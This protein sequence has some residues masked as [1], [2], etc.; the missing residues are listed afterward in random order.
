[1]CICCCTVL[2]AQA[3]ALDWAEQIGNSNADLSNALALDATGNVVTTGCYRGQVDFDPGPGIYSMGVASSSASACFVQKLTNS[4]QFIWARSVGTY[5]I[6]SQGIETDAAGAIYVTGYFDGTQD[7]DPG[8]AVY[9]VTAVAGS[10]IFVVKLDAAGNFRWVRTFSGGSSSNDNA[11]CIARGS[12]NTMVISGTVYG[13]VDFDPGPGVAMVSYADSLGENIYVLCLD[14]AGQ[15]S[16]A[17][18]I[19]GAGWDESTDIKCDPSGNVYLTGMF[20]GTVDFDPGPG[21]FP[22]TTQS[23]NSNIF[24]L[25]LDAG[26]NLLYAVVFPGNNLNEGLGIAC[27]AAGEAIVTG[28]FWGTTD[29]D[30]GPGTSNL[31]SNGMNDAFICKLDATGNLIWAEKIGG[32]ANDAGRRLGTDAAGNIYLSG[33]FITNV[34]FDPGPATFMLSAMGS[35]DVFIEKLD[36]AGNF[37]WLARLGSMQSEYC[38]SLQVDAANAVYTAGWFSGLADFDPGVSTHMLTP[39]QTDAFVQKYTQPC[40]ADTVLITDTTCFSYTLNTQT[41]TASGNYTQTLNNINGCDSVLLLDLTINTVD[42]SLTVNDPVMTANATNA[43]YQWINCE[44]GF[45]VPGATAQS[46]TPSLNGTYAVIV[47]QGNCTDTSACSTI[48]GVG[49]ADIDHHVQLLV[50][51]NPNRGTFTVSTNVAARLIITDALGKQVYAQNVQGNTPA[52]ISLSAT[53]LY[54]ITVLTADGQCSAQR[55]IVTE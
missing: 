12:Q 43:T 53:G 3:P 27:T 9:S 41:Y 44:N 16:W 4:G 2:S 14:T 18:G 5:N 32:N 8:P 49:E 37:V 33:D 40:A 28:V 55:V 39:N 23:G 31:T 46:F 7:F 20:T 30:P 34:D 29:F 47:T 35:S 24:S 54:V 25:K 17:C 51:E 15:Y 52:K 1:M 22:L 6:T 13:S 42:V 50:S 48:I 45:P 11:I 38:L 26:G 10:D 36:A 21:I 19:G